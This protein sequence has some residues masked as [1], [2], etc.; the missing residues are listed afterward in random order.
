MTC[1]DLGALRASL[2]DAPGATPAHLQEHL[3]ACA[4]C[5]DTIAELRRNAELAAPAVAMTSPDAP[6]SPAAVEAALA[7][8]EQRRARLLAAQ[9]A[10]SPVTGV[11]QAGGRPNPQLGEAPAPVVPLPR[12]RRITRL[13][14]RARAAAAALVAAV[15]LTGVVATP[16]GRAFASDV[17]A[18]FRSERFEVVALGNSQSMQLSNVMWQLVSTGVFSSNE[19]ELYGVSEPRQARDLAEASQLAGFE[20][21]AVSRAALPPGVGAAPERIMAMRPDAARITF[22]RE[23][24]LAYFKSH[25]QPDVQIPERFDGTVLVIQVP[26]IVVQEYPGRDGVP[27][28]L[29]GK[30][31]AVGLATEGGASLG[32]LRDLILRLPGLPKE[33]VEQLR[34]INDWRTTLPLPVPVDEV[35][36]R[37]ATVDGAE[38]L[39]FADQTGK[40]NALLWQRDGHIYGVAG[41][42]GPDEASRVAGSLR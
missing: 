16:G 12:R 24:A 39:S 17:L 28:L 11:G 21:Q 41:V 6:V 36:W 34:D 2:D 37:Q 32:E 42:V 20:V 40:L 38:A 19:N 33:V 5:S 4:A 8:L 10:A 26:G 30:A 1:P 22:H 3:E 25:G 23:R 14:L 27:R 7:R 18:R 31:G 29:V 35:R 9:T 15:V 13:G